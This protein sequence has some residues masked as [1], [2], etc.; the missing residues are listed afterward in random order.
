MRETS[1]ECRVTWTSC[2]TA[3]QPSKPR[4]NSWLRR[5]LENSYLQN[6]G[7]Q[8]HVP[9]KNIDPIIESRCVLENRN[10][11]NDLW[12]C[13]TYLKINSLVQQQP[14]SRECLGWQL[15]GHLLTVHSSI[16]PIRKILGIWIKQNLLGILSRCQAKENNKGESWEEG[17]GSLGMQLDRS[18]RNC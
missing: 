12:V 7:T 16:H 9:V 2:L 14:R 6:R 13:M 5:I 1:P 3:K 15:R 8:V 4:A 11:P 17:Q 10:S 18:K